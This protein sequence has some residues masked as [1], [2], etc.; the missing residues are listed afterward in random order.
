MRNYT[1]ST[2]NQ[3][4][5]GVISHGEDGCAAIEVIINAT[6]LLVP[7]ILSCEGSKFLGYEDIGCEQFL[8]IFGPVNY[9]LLVNAVRIY[10]NQV[11]STRLLEGSLLN[12][13]MSIRLKDGSF[14]LSRVR[15]CV[16]KCKE[17]YSDS[18]LVAV[19]YITKGAQFPGRLYA[20]QWD[21]ISFDNPQEDKPLC[22]EDFERQLMKK[23]GVVACDYL[24]D[25]FKVQYSYLKCW[26]YKVSHSTED[27][28]FKKTG[29]NEKI[30]KNAFGKAWTTF[31]KRILGLD[32]Y[33]VKVK[34]FENEVYTYLSSLGVWHSI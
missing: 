9:H 17:K 29:Y 16:S 6:D 20:P 22:Y 19:I 11:K 23:M 34:G 15:V 8:K 31:S 3:L 1:A 10:R 32:K 33:D 24:Q 27:N 4:V 18:Q 14:F 21:L 25:A 12:T 28:I 2:R 7:R 13:H 5:K 30:Q 26:E